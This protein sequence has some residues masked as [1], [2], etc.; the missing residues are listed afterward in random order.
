MINFSYSSNSTYLCEI[1]K[2]YL[3]GSDGIIE[4]LYMLPKRFLAKKNETFIIIKMNRNIKLELYR[5]NRTN[6]KTLF[7]SSYSTSLQ[8]NNE[9]IEWDLQLL[10]DFATDSHIA[11]LTNLSGV[12]EINFGFYQCTNVDF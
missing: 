5:N 2:P 12:S 7:S 4:I 11:K 9:D 10:E 6:A 1:K 8:T 3:I